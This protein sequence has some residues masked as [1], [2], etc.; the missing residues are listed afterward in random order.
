MVA[1]GWRWNPFKMVPALQPVGVLRHSQYPPKAALIPGASS[2]HQSTLNSHG[3]ALQ[4]PGPGPVSHIMTL[5]VI[6]A[7]GYTQPIQ[8]TLL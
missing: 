2:T 4:S 5:I 1:L 7:G 6:I 8:E 3:Q